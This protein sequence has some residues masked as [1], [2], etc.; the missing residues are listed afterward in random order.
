MHPRPSGIL[1]RYLSIHDSLELNTHLGRCNLHQIPCPRYPKL[2]RRS[3]AIN[4]SL[5][6]R[7][8]HQVPVYWSGP[9]P[10]L[11]CLL[12]LPSGNALDIWS[13]RILQ[14][15]VLSIRADSLGSRVLSWSLEPLLVPFSSIAWP[16]TGTAISVIFLI[17]TF[18]HT[19]CHHVARK[20][21]VC[22]GRWHR[23][24]GH[25]GRH[26]ALSWARCAGE[27]WCGH[28][29]VPGPHL[30]STTPFSH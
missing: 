28:R 20:P 11:A 29:R 7:P 2:V 21:V 22:A 1:A 27:A 4:H 5:C 3:R 24:R 9:P 13:P 25:H 18:L 6:H 8:S 16:F 14:E 15:P 23:E 26:S 30:S 10:L 12:L 19:S 17:V